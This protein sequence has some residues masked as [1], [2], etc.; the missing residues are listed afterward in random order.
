MSNPARE[1]VT[2]DVGLSGTAVNGTDYTSIAS[3]A[4][5]PTGN[6]SI[7]ITLTVTE[8]IL[9]EGDETA[10][11]TITNPQAGGDLDSGRFSISPTSPTATVTIADDDTATLTISTSTITTA[12]E[13]GS[14]G[15]FTITATQPSQLM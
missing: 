11:L 6:T 1:D 2:V 9:V 15:E 5:I 13:G 4:T 8:D 7:T 12:A 3:T 14:N 10:T